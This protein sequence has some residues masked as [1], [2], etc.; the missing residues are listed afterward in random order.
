MRVLY[1]EDSATAAELA[2]RALLREVPDGE[3]VLARSLAEARRRL[4]GA[5]LPDVLIVDLNLPDGRGLELLA[6]VRARSQPVSVVVL[7][8][9]GDEGSA[10][11][12]LRAGAD[13]CLFKHERY[14]DE[15]PATLEKARRQALLGRERAKLRTTAER[16]SRL[17]MA[18]PSI[19]YS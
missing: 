18:S 12:A 19:L 4:E 16:L 7:I 14:L 17:L 8:G 6:E 2:R 1:V 9:V 3:L 5:T 13:D 10:V 15:L 11:S